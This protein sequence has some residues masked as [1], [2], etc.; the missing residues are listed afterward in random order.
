[1]KAYMAFYAVDVGNHVIERV[2]QEYAVGHSKRVF[3]VEAVSAKQA[4]AKAGRVLGSIGS[5]GCECCQHRYC[6]I[7]AEYS[8]TK[9]YSDYWICHCCSE[10]NRRAQGPH[11]K[12]VSN[13]L[14]KN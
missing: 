5:V 7:C 3:L 14:G 6:E 10:L 11:L 1:M 12:G 4:W 13:G 9:R 2:T 8:V